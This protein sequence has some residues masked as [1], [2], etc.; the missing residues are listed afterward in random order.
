MQVHGV[1]SVRNRPIS[2]AS[3][4]RI[5]ILLGSVIVEFWVGHLFGFRGS[6][7]YFAQ[8]SRSGGDI[9]LSLVSSY[10]EIEKYDLFKTGGFI[11]RPYL[12]LLPDPWL[13]DPGVP[14]H[15]LLPAQALSQRTVFR[16]IHHLKQ[17]LLLCEVGPVQP[18]FLAQLPWYS[19][20][21]FW[22]LFTL[23]FGF[24]CIHF[25][26]FERN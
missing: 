11:S 2:S 24:A 3:D 1:G 9:A 17:Q 5:Q 14:L 18:T 4:E 8:N 26:R 6:E 22:G 13:V 19:L 20:Q 7:S 10:S 12:F 21:H 15:S 25:G 23:F 16:Q